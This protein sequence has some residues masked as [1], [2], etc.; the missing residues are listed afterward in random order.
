MF[1]QWGRL[2]AAEGVHDRTTVPYHCTVTRSFCCLKPT[3][4]TK[5]LQL[6]PV[7]LVG[8]LA[9]WLIIAHASHGGMRYDEQLT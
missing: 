6:L 7:S 8:C 2:Q 3:H 9:E 4:G 1:V 5:V